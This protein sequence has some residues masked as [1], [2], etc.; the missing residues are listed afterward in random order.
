MCLF[1][2]PKVETKETPAQP[3]REAVTSQEDPS[4]II[5]EQEKKRK[6]F[7]STIATSGSGLFEQA[8]IKKVTLGS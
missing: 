1:S 6:G 4:R 5:A 8:P 3:T 7:Q 2:A